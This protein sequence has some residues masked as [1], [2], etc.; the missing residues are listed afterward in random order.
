MNPRTAVTGALIVL[1]LWALVLWTES[2][3][4]I[5]TWQLLKERAAARPAVFWGSA[6]VGAFVLPRL[7]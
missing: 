3:Q 1:A 6:V 2:S 5:G 7:V 4:D